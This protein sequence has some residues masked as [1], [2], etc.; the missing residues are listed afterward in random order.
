MLQSA[1][2][3]PITCVHLGKT[4]LGHAL[5]TVNAYLVDGLLIDSGPPATAAEM[6]QWCRAHDV[7]QVVNTHHHEDHCGGNRLLQASL[8]LTVAAPR[9]A[10]PFL[11]DP[12]RLAHYRRL[13]WGQPQPS[14][15]QPLDELIET[16]N[17][18]FMVVPTPGHTPD[19]VCLFE[20]DEGWLF[21][22]DLFIHEQARYLNADENAHQILASLHRIRALR[23]HLLI[24][25]HA[26]FREDAEGALGRK[27]AY[28][29]ALAQ[30][31]DRLRETGDSAK[32]IAHALVG[33]EGMA[34]LLS[35]GHFSKENLIR[36][37][38]EDRPQDQ[39]C[40]PD[41]TCQE[42]GAGNRCPR[43][44]GLNG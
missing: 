40:G 5:R 28:W 33:P 38:L 10:L 34:T 12:P 13:V 23:P 41:G 14:D 31:A 6:I 2:H 25:S 7:R 26:G 4:I 1:S 11:R 18:R 16:A 24:C 29:E 35:R 42:H 17:H 8:G 27:I 37:L 36:S 21:T 30:E 44:D 15:P 39:K 19:H 43:A 20:L 3:G 9:G 22:G 32:Q